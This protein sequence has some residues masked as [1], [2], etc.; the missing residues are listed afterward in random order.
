MHEMGFFSLLLSFLMVEWRYSCGLFAL[1]F[2]PRFFSDLRFF[3][4]QLA[5]S[6]SPRFSRSIVWPNRHWLMRIRYPRRSPLPNWIWWLESRKCSPASVVEDEQANHV[7]AYRRIEVGALAASLRTITSVHH[8]CNT[9][10]GKSYSHHIHAL[11]PK[12]ADAVGQ[13]TPQHP[14]T[15]HTHPESISSTQRSNDVAQQLKSLRDQ[16][17]PEDKRGTRAAQG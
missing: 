3:L 1:S 5:A 13:T 8:A 14:N 17:D 6:I 16:I 4:H 12:S 7:A 2:A 11:A 9:S 10:I 15:E